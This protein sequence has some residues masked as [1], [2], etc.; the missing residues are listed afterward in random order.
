MN[1]SLLKKIKRVRLGDLEHVFL[2][3]LALLPALVYRRLRPELW[4]ICENEREARDNGYWLFRYLRQRQ[5]ETDAV[6][7]IRY[8]APEYARVAALGPTVPYGSFR[9]W[10]FYLAARVNISTQKYGKPNAAVCYLLEVVLGWLKNRRV[11]LQHGVTKDDLPFL[12]YDKAKLWMFCCAAEPEYRFIKETFG[13]PEGA[14]QQLGFCR[15]DPL[16]GAESDPELLLIL[17]TWR[18][19]LQREGDREAFLESDYYRAWS[20]LLQ[21]GELAR[22]LEREHKRAV[23]V[24]H[25]E[26]AAF[27]AL[28]HSNAPQITVLGWQEA[29]IS[30]LIRE[31]GTLITDYSSVYMD[32]A[33][34]KKPLVY[35]QFDFAT[36]REGHLPTGYFDYDRD[37]FGPICRTEEQLLR[38]TAE[39]FARGC[40]MAPEYRRRVDSF[41]TLNDDKNCERTV[42]AIR[43][44]LEQERTV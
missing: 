23:F 2:F 25:R 14:V 31:A 1:E 16:H 17:P 19:Y 18:M 4:L 34:M 36:Y 32:F 7:A 15:F 3:L 27:E 8:D 40:E 20:G 26:M 29:D 22:L 41:Y 44:A 10:I 42:L 9:H 24:L 11:F 5:P 13:Y 21:N 30:A 37:G 28:F 12:H 38:E 6:Y 35:Y 43:K 39:I 33:Y